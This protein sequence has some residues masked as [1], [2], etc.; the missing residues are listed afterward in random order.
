MVHPIDAGFR[1][2]DTGTVAI[3]IALLAALGTIASAYLTSHNNATKESVSD[4]RAELEQCKKSFREEL[5]RLNSQ[6][7][8][9]QAENHRL[10]DENLKLM[11]KILIDT[12]KHKAAQ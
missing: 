6:L 4:L 10:F 12:G 9:S 8:S 1:T 11:K 5:L 3:V 7:T 2:M